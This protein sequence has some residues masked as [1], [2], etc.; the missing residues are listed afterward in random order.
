[1]KA[2]S[3]MV[4]TL[5]ARKGL[6]VQFPNHSDKVDLGI[7]F[8]LKVKSGFRNR[9]PSGALKFLRSLAHRSSSYPFCEDI[10][11]LVRPIPYPRKK[12]RELGLIT[13]RNPSSQPYLRSISPNRGVEPQTDKVP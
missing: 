3:K 13:Y 1:M 11:D 8:S 10:G 9:L 6:G 4:D 2:Y 12:D 7:P 5:T